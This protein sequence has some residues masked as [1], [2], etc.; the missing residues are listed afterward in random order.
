V[1]ELSVANRCSTAVPAELVELQPVQFVSIDADPGEMENVP[2]DALEEP[3][4]QPAS[5]MTAGA[6]ASASPRKSDPWG[7]TN[8]PCLRVPISAREDCFFSSSSRSIKIVGAFA[9]VYR[10]GRRISSH[11]RGRFGTCFW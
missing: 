8:R 9:I 3:P 5:K 10:P 2:L 7:R 6:A 4:P 1:P 11:F